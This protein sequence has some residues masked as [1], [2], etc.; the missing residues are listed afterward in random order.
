MK[1]Y[2]HEKH[3]K[4]LNYI[5][6]LNYSILTSQKIILHILKAKQ[7]LGKDL[8]EKALKIIQTTTNEKEALEI[9]LKL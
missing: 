2:D 6:S 8:N 5:K 7:N 4:L 3:L 9:I 1:D